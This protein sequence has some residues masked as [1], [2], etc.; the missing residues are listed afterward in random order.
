MLVAVEDL[1][2]EECPQLE[3]HPEVVEYLQF[4]DLQAVEARQLEE[5]PSPGERLQL[6]DGDRLMCQRT[7]LIEVVR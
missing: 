2:S 3:G 1:Q 4:V 6:V 7:P 5:H